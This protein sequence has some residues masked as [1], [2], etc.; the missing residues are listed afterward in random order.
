MRNNKCVRTVFATLLLVA[1]L[2]G[3]AA[4]EQPERCVYVDDYNHCIRY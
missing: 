1:A 2:A 4:A 3:T